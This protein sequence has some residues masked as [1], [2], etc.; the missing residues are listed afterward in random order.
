MID[1]QIVAL[2][3]PSPEYFRHGREE[4]GPSARSANQAYP[5]PDGRWCR[6]SNLLWW[7]PIHENPFRVGPPLSC[8]ISLLPISTPQTKPCCS[9]SYREYACSTGWLNQ[10]SATSFWMAKPSEVGL[11]ITY[12]NYD[13]LQHITIIFA[14]KIIN[15]PS[16]LCWWYSGWLRTPDQKDGSNTIFIM[17]DHVGKTIINHNKS[18][19]KLV[20]G[21]VSTNI[22]KNGTCHQRDACS[23]SSRVARTSSKAT[24][25]M[26]WR[27]LKFI[28]ARQ[29]SI[30]ENVEFMAKFMGNITNLCIYIY[31]YSI[32]IYIYVYIYNYNY[33]I[34]WYSTAFSSILLGISPPGYAGV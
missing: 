8:H 13:I 2:L 24:V 19:P 11:L 23:C 1:D 31:M 29:R 6:V 22:L 18:S 5:R 17:G 14:W 20:Y 3:I 26:A 25:A 16:I 28:S 30:G 34:L 27:A 32:C 15:E 7:L 12:C 21:I 10:I 4:K 9:V 33:W